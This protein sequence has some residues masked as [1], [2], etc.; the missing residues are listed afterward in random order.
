[1]GG[2]LLARTPSNRILYEVE[3]PIAERFENET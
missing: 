1:M 3:N 2:N